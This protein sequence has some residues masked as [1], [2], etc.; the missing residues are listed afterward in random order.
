M[1]SFFSDDEDQ[2]QPARQ[3]PAA[4][5]RRGRAAP[6][7]A[8]HLRTNDQPVNDNARASSSTIPSSPGHGTS[9]FTRGSSEVTGI[10]EPLPHVSKRSFLD[11]SAGFGVG[12]VP[13]DDDLRLALPD[14]AAPE[15]EEEPNDVTLLIRAWTRERGTPDIQPWQPDI[16]E[17][18]LHKLSQQGQMLEVLRSDPKTSEEEHFKLIVV[19]TEMERVRYLVRSYLRCRLAKVSSTSR[20]RGGR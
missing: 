16:V 7:L 1:S 8:R 2:S 11:V 12:E 20:A 19:Q 3:A 13:A 6:R 14:N 4:R 15:Q 18:C 5:G 9:F 17:E 10:T